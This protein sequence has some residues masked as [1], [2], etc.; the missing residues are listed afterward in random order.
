MNIVGED[1]VNDLFELADK[2]RGR[3]ILHINST[4]RGGGVA[5]LLSSIVPIMRELGID[6]KWEIMRGDKTF[7][8]STKCMHNALHGLDV[9]FPEDCFKIYEETNK[10]NGRILDL[11]A[12]YIFVHDSQPA[13]LIEYVNRRKGKWI[14]RGHVDMSH[15]RP[16]IW[17][18][19]RPYIQKYDA[20][21]FSDSSFGKKDLTIT[22]FQLPPAIDPLASK[23]VPLDED[24][25]QKEFD[26]LCIGR[27]KPVITQISRFDWLK[28]PMGVIDVFRMVKR[29][30]D[31]QLVLAGGFAD[32]DPEGEL[33]YRKTVE[34][35]NKDKDIHVILLP[36]LS[37]RV[38]NALQAGSD[39][40]VQKS[41]REGFGLTVAE[42]LWKKKAVV[43]SNVGGIPKQ[44]I[45]GRTGMLVHT[46]D[47]T[48]QKIR[49]LLR[50]KD[51]ARRLG[52]FGHEH[53]RRSFLI[54][55][56][57]RSMLSILLSIGQEKRVHF[58]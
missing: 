22:Q 17:N 46:I 25:I 26:K 24:N 6:T 41:I 58:L 34:H 23:N 39:V 55:K 47:G 57:V 32:D 49:F 29:S 44:I 31:S 37:N 11:D 5:E 38:I 10:E 13:A 9:K 27:S 20:A 42:A 33:V 54:T 50:N 53:I 51:V 40:I 3:K 12:D 16:E 4:S 1:E 18:Y 8:E 45:D 7:F 30:I 56:H 36:P 52:I 15:A 21:I 35:A 28:D 19:L 48:A 43:A 14:W 2:I